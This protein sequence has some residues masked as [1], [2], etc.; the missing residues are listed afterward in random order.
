[1]SISPL[2]LSLFFRL[3]T[4]T[5]V[6]VENYLLF[7]VCCIYDAIRGVCSTC[8]SC[9]CLSIGRLNKS[10]CVMLAVLQTYRTIEVGIE[11]NCCGCG[12]CINGCV[13]VEQILFCMS[14]KLTIIMRVVTVRVPPY[15]FNLPMTVTI[16]RLLMFRLHHH[17]RWCVCVVGCCCC[18]AC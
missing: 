8:S 12:D 18:C 15:G 4:F 9:C 10:A 7:Q 2:S 3:G 1:M 6:S 13:L 14:K 17:F 11:N 16:V 5:G